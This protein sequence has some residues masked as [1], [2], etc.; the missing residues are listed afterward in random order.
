VPKIGILSPSISTADAVSNDVLGMYGALSKA[1]NDVRIFCETNGVRDQRI[2]DVSKIKRFLKGTDD[3]LIYHYSIGWPS[4]L[5]ILQELPCRKAIKYHNVTPAT[6]FAGFSKSDERHCELGRKELTKVIQADC[7]LY[8]A[9]ST[10]SMRELISSGAAAPKCFVVPP[11]HHIDRLA[12]T[13]TD[14]LVPI[15]YADGK[16][17][18]L[19]VG[20]VAPHKG[21]LTL[22]E[23]FANY[24]YNCN[25]NSRLIIVG[26]GG[27]GL[28][29]YSKFLRNTVNGLG[30]KEAVV[31][32]G[33]VSDSALKAYYSVADLF[34]ITSEHEGFCVP[35]VEAM[36]M[37]LPITACASTAI[38]ETVGDAGVVWP[39]RDP[40]L[41]AETID[42]ISRDTSVRSALGLRGRRRYEKMF[43]NQRIEETFLDTLSKIHL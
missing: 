38:P 20:R 32:T 24:Y 40:F 28:S 34:V 8:L 19:S 16:T 26:K 23:A 14:E 42:F 12:T 7:D 43:T 4:G 31:F 39:E 1:G 11:F 25:T 15:R 6:F 9:A 35:L 18:I 17:N 5:V 29:P 3:F 2:F 21:H 37:Q 41:L 30:L 27:E 13:Q 36:S 22:L 10:Y 33:C